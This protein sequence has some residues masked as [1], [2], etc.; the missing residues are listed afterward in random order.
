MAK[1]KASQFLLQQILTALA[2]LRPEPVA[3]C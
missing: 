1:D 3:L 2:A